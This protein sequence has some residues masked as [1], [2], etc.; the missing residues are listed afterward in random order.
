MIRIFSDKNKAN[1]LEFLRNVNWESVYSLSDAIEAYNEF[2]D[3]EYSGFDK[4]FP[5]S[6]SSRSKSKDKN[7]LL[8]L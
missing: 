7:G 2:A 3:I 6:K 4:F 5:F 1:F 8:R